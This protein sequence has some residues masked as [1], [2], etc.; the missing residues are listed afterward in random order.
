MTRWSSTPIQP[1]FGTV[2]GV[3][4]RYA[5]GRQHER[6]VL[7]LS[8]WPE[9]LL[10]YQQ[11]WSHLAEHAHLVA[12]DLPGFGASERKESL[13]SPSAMGDFII[14]IA[15]AFGMDRA[16]LVAPNVA[17][18]ASLFG[19]ARY[20][21]RVATV[22]VGPGP[23]LIPLAIGPDLHSWMATSEDGAIDDIGQSRGHVIGLLSHLQRYV[24]AEDIRE[25]YLRSYDGDR[26]AGTRTYLHHLAEQLPQ[27]R[28]LLPTIQAPV[29]II[30]GYGDRLIPWRN[31]E[32]LHE[33]LPN[34]RLSGVDAG[35]FVWEDAP[36]QYSALVRR[37]WRTWDTL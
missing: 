11:M 21:H 4:I 6:H 28:D 19:A 32:F 10:A 14:S 3:T 27:L 22:T 29:Q 24:L 8:P 5:Q 2:D 36:E 18:P 26:L 17:T 25:D 1:R 30:A 23:A 31:A 16:H 9:S 20:P 7:L 12:V 35:H 13:L 34:S 33:S 37:W 15:N